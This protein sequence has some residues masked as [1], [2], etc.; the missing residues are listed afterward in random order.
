MFYRGL[1]ASTGSSIQNAQNNYI[2]CF[3]LLANPQSVSSIV[4]DN[5]GQISV[6]F[7]SK[8]VGKSNRD[9]CVISSDIN[10]FL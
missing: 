6:E 8:L 7:K 1:I 4:S 2:V 5:L 9:Y 10:R 3:Y